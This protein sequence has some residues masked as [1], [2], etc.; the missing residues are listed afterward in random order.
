VDGPID[1]GYAQF[2]YTGNSVTF[3][4][5]NTA[6]NTTAYVFEFAADKEMTV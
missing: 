2:A 5:V 4:V 6:R 3:P 1:L